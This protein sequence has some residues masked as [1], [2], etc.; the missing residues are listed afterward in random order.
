MTQIHLLI[1]II[2][3]QKYYIQEHV[4]TMIRQFLKQVYNKQDNS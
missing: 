4:L 3:L 1:T 2:E